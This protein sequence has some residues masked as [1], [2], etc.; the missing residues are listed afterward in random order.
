MLSL[1][2]AYLWSTLHGLVSIGPNKAEFWDRFEE[3]NI[4]AGHKT[5]NESDVASFGVS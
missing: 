3:V 5:Q 1:R 4:I 2:K